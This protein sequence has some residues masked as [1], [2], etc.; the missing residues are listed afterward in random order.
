MAGREGGNRTTDFRR[1]MWEFAVMRIRD[2]LSTP[3]PQEWGIPNVSGR[4]AQIGDIYTSEKAVALL[5][6]WHV[7]RPSQVI[8]RGQASQLEERLLF[9]VGVSDQL[10]AEL[11]QGKV[12]ANWLQ[13]FN[14]ASIQ[15]IKIGDL[16][17]KKTL[18][19]LTIPNDSISLW[20]IKTTKN[21]NWTVRSFC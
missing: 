6:R 19:I 10:E 1:C 2:I 15:D 14:R 17:S 5:L 21:V 3:I 20:R 12:A 4:P 11:N 7:Y 9:S 16:I 8:I 13:E 18:K